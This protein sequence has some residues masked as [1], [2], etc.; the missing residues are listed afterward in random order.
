[1]S[2]G[3]RAIEL[4]LINPQK[5]TVIA[6]GSVNGVDAERFAPTPLKQQQATDLRA[7]LKIP[8]NAPVLGFV[9]RLTRDKGLEE[10]VSAFKQIRAMAALKEDATSPPPYL[11]CVGDYEAGDP[12]SSTTR[13]LM[14]SLPGIVRTGFVND[15]SL[16]YHVMDALALPTYREGFPY[17]PLEAAASGK[18]VVTTRVTGAMDAVI[19]GVTGYLVPPRDSAALARAC[20]ELLSSPTTAQRMGQA[21][22]E[23]VLRDFRPADL[24]AAWAN[25]YRKNTCGAAGASP[26]RIYEMWKRTIDIVG[27]TVGLILG[28]P[29]LLLAALAILIEDG[30]SPWF[31]QERVGRFGRPFQ[32]R[33]MRSMIPNAQSQGLGLGIA[34]NDDR[35]TRVGRFLRATSL[36]ELPQLINV[37]RG[38]MSLIGP[39]PTVACQVEKYTP[40]QRRRLEVRP[41]LTGWA[42]VNGRNSISWDRRIELDVWYVDHQ[43]I[44]LDLWTLLKTPAAVIPH[45]ETLYGNSGIVEDFQGSADTPAD[46]R[47]DSDRQAA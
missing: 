16:Y 19:D 15:P 12:V 27:A 31:T 23:R 22:R 20:Y 9:G 47:T 28:G 36:D 37:L 42:Q 45:S 17:V 32:L 5:A 7:Q 6:Q 1:M 30:E 29:V 4:G 2:D 33:K 43:S 26:F 35:I 25:L 24:W 34:K 11:L 38:E 3:A 21:G 8:A 13:N 44:W 39:R 10:L 14:E 18:P 41:G 40:Q 46:G